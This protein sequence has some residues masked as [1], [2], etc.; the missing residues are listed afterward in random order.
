M[1]TFGILLCIG[2]AIALVIGFSADTSVATDLGQRVHNIGLMNQKQNII[3][4]GGSLLVAGTLL[5]SLSSR[6]NPP[7][8]TDGSYRQCPSCAELVKTEAKVCRYCQRDLPSLR[9]LEEQSKAERERLAALQERDSAAARQ[10]EDKLPK[11]QCPN[12]RK[13]IPL[14]SSECKHCGAQFGARSSWRVL[15]KSDA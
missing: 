3:M 7:S 10:L 13:V 2:A 11:G 9:E 4:L 1:K 12:C 15:P 5:L 14:S 6:T 8:I